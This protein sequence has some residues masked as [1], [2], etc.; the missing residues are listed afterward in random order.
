MSIWS[1]LM[2]W[3]IP[4]RAVELEWRERTTWRPEQGDYHDAGRPCDEEEC[5]LCDRFDRVFGR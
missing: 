1:R 4:K 2:D 5:E 3:G